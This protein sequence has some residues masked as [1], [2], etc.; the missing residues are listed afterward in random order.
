MLGRHGAGAPG[1]YPDPGLS[2][3]RLAVRPYVRWAPSR[4]EDPNLCEETATMANRVRRIWTSI[5]AVAPLAAVV[6]VEAA[7]RR[8]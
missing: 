6:L 4:G 2:S 7:M 3:H 5:L 1:S 8:W